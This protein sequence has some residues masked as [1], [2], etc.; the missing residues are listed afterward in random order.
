MNGY[1]LI[2]GRSLR[3]GSDKAQLR[4]DGKNLCH[5]IMEKLKLSGCEEVFLVGK[6]SIPIS[7]PQIIESWPDHHPLYGVHTALNHCSGELCIITPC[8]IPFVSIATY[9]RL[10]SKSITTV[11]AT[12]STK[13][14]LLG[15]FSTSKREEALSYAQ[16]HRSVMSFVENEAY[17]VIPSDEL[18]NINHPD[19]L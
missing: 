2:G 17:I 4:I 10:I 18:H 19:D 14:P 12:A 11:L 1:I 16:Q 3:M 5:I 8:D 9:R 15:I 7:I 6:H 13:Q